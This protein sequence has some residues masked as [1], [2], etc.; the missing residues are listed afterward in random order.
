MLQ[1]LTSLGARPAHVK[2]NPKPKRPPRPIY[3][4]YIVL[5][6]FNSK[7]DD[8]L[9]VKKGDILN[10]NQKIDRDWGDFQNLTKDTGLVALNY[11]KK[12]DIYISTEDYND[13]V[14]GFNTTEDLQ[15]NKGYILYL[16][17]KRGDEWGQF[18][19]SN[20][21][22]GLVPLTFVK[23]HSNRQNNNREPFAERMKRITEEASK[24]TPG[25]NWLEER[26]RNNN[27]RYQTTMRQIQRTKSL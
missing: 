4:P 15:I 11:V 20:N 24:G 8:D 12:L 10:L 17:E 14:Q 23:P 6:D 2:G 26:K 22:Q 5:Y 13:S 7:T 9:T 27:R 19:N 21:D 1:R 18:I 16:I 3:N 25:K